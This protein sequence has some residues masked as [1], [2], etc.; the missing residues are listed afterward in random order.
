[1]NVS[2]EVDLAM[3]PVLGQKPSKEANP[4]GSEVVPNKSKGRELLFTSN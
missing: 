1:M 2:G 4:W 3:Y